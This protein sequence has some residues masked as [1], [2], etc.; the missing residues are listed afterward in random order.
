LEREKEKERERENENGQYIYQHKITLHV[1]GIN[2]S[3]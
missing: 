1:N 3:I 2:V